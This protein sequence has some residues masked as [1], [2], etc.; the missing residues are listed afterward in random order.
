MKT[1]MHM[2]IC[3]FSLINLLS[4]YLINK[5]GV[6]ILTLSVRPAPV[7]VQKE[8]YSVLIVGLKSVRRLSQ[9]GLISPAL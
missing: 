9:L 3:M 7:F 5:N 6:D 8:D 2:Q 1:Q 4:Q